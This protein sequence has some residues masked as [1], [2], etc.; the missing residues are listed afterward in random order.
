MIFFIIFYQN[1]ENS[2]NINEKWYEQDG[3]LLDKGDA[4]NISNE[5]IIDE[6]GRVITNPSISK[7]SERL[8]DWNQIGSITCEK[9]WCI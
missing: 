4:T 1:Y 8:L 6:D 7:P 3:N 9:Q 2:T 5:T